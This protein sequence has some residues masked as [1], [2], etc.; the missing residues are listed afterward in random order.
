MRSFAIIKATILILVLFSITSSINAQ[1]FKRS[2]KLN[3][4]PYKT[5]STNEEYGYA[6]AIDGNVAVVGGTNVSDTGSAYVL[7]YDGIAWNTIA[8]LTASDGASANFFGGAVAIDSNVIV[9]S[10]IGDSTYSGSTYL[11]EKP[12]GGWTD[13]TETAKLR[14]GD[15]SNNANFG[16]AVG[17]SGNTIVVSAY[18]DLS[19]AGSGYIFTKPPGGWKD[20]THTAKLTASDGLTVDYLG[21]SAS[22]SGNYVIL[23]AS[24][25]DDNGSGSGS[26]YIFEKPGATWVD[27]TETAKLLPSDAVAGA[28]F[29]V[30]VGISGEDAVIGAYTD[31]EFGAQ[32]G[33]AY[34]FTKPAGGWKDTTEHAKLVPS[35]HG[36]DMYFGYTVAISGENI[37]IGA[38]G[39]SLESGTSYLGSAYVFNK[40]SAGWTNMNESVKIFADDGAK[41]DY[42]GESIAISGQSVCVGV[43]RDD[44][45]GMN[46]G[47]IYM[48]DYCDS[49]NIQSVTVDAGCTIT[50]GSASVTV[51]GGSEPYTYAWSTG[52]TTNFTP[53]SLAAGSYSLVVSDA[54]GCTAAATVQVESATPPAVNVT[55]KNITCPGD[56]D[57]SI[58][59]S[60]MSGSPYQ[61]E[62]S[63]GDT[64]EN[65]TGL[66]AGSY[67]LKV[68]NVSGCTFLTCVEILE[69][70]QLEVLLDSLN[71]PSCL[72]SNGNLAVSAI[73]GSAPYVY[74]WDAPISTVDSVLTF[75][76]SGVYSVAVTDSNGCSVV[77]NITV[78][79]LG[80]PT[81]TIDSIINTSCGLSEGWIGVTVLED[82]VSVNWSNGSDSSILN[83]LSADDYILTVLDSQTFCMSYEVITI[84]EEIPA[85]QEICIATSDSV[86]RNILVWEKT[87]LDNVTSVNIYRESCNG[88]FTWIANQSYDS[89]SEFIDTT[90]FNDRAW[91]YKMSAVDSCGNESWLSEHERLIHLSAIGNDGVNKLIW[92]LYEGKTIINY[93][94]WSRTLPGGWVMIASLDN[95]AMSYCD[96]SSLDVTY[97]IEG[98]TVESCTSEKAT[99]Y[100][101]TR[102]NRETA[103]ASTAIEVDFSSS[104][105]LIVEGESIEF[106]DESDGVIDSWAWTFE[107][108]EPAISADSN[109]T[110]TY[111]TTGVYS[112]K[113]IA[114]TAT[115]LDSMTKE[116]YV[117]VNPN[118]IGES[119]LA[120]V[121]IYPNPSTG[122]F[123]VSLKRNRN[124]GLKA[125]VYTMFGELVKET[126]VNAVAT[127]F[128][129]D[130]NEYPSGVYSL[131][132]ISGSGS[133]NFRIIKE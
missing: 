65:L 58:D 107:G 128:T 99:T 14:A 124:E 119:A 130:L 34:V 13:T 116:A 8:R 19:Y 62:W 98:T 86:G 26:A 112:A 95:Q 1:T 32:A 102:S 52:D 38:F 31:N 24:G 94:V 90:V 7:E 120:Q 48:Y 45:N 82:T 36:A 50:N 57:G 111:M 123:N 77:E 131:N 28:Q 71:Q 127:E 104:M 51:Q 126:Q 121:Q 100:G 79:D 84:D 114:Y 12:I 64:I 60:V 41:D 118:G 44:D 83:N 88:E 61:V 42:F 30:S 55:A 133:Y 56:N 59:I 122:T 80:G 33:A 49:I 23:G 2:T 46:S 29:G 115:N 73:G 6:V 35:E 117:F 92:N 37:A 3:S 47:S 96:T 27:M 110:V 22:I 125:D 68:V 43:K 91:A 10:A 18:G 97:F 81:I 93:N 89:L 39:D 132:I 76:T 54:T 78:S 66:H 75:I 113:L 72:S 69:P 11:F 108:G 15:A 74:T 5:N 85:N 17:I 103:K 20:T 106:W 87:A 9:V 40:P 53:T 109:P 105:T 101:T 21:Q 16:K 129:V 25:D 70:Q 67:E 4:F 63:N